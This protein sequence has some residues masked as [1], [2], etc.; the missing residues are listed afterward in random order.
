MVVLD[1]AAPDPGQ[2]LKNALIETFK[3]E[4]PLI[5]VDLGFK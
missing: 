4:A 3:K 1:E 2:L 5:A